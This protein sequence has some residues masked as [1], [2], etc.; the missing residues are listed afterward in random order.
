MTHRRH[1]SKKN[2]EGF[3]SDGSRANGN[4]TNNNY[5]Y[6]TIDSGTTTE[7]TI[8]TFLHQASHQ[9]TFRE[10]NREYPFVRS[11]H[12]V[13]NKAWPKQLNF[14][15]QQFGKRSFPNEVFHNLRHDVSLRTEYC[16]GLRVHWQSSID[17]Q[18]YQFLV[19]CCDRRSCRLCCG[20]KGGTAKNPRHGRNRILVQTTRN[21]LSFVRDLQRIRR[22]FRLRS[23]G[24]RA[25]K[26]LEG[27]LVEPFCYATRGCRW[28]GFFDHPQPYHMEVE[29]YVLLKRNRIL[30]FY[31]R[32]YT[33]HFCKL[34]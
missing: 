5:T 28:I 24:F 20:R 33:F 18:S 14:V 17:I 29:R 3:V 32:I 25:Q 8:Q 22:I 23:L 21:Y 31:L 9:D 16:K 12:R 1:S 6:L 34:I 15:Q 11:Y 7:E 10:D 30:F 26:E 19:F 4:E 2:G 27:C 13:K